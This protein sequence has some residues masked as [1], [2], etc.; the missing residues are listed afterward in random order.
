MGQKENYLALLACGLAAGTENEVM[1][2]R[3]FSMLDIRPEKPQNTK[4]LTQDHVL[5][6]ISLKEQG[7]TYKEIAEIYCMTDK[8]VFA[9]IK[10]YKEMVKNG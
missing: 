4:N 1:P 6:M 5:D 10:R 9:R 8:A 2:E 7:Y 3:V